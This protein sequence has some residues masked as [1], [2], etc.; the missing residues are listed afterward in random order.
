M[1][2]VFCNFVRK[3]ENSTE[4][5]F[6]QVVMPSDVFLVR[7][8]WQMINVLLTVMALML[9]ML[10]GN[11]VIAVVLMTPSPRYQRDM[12]QQCANGNCDAGNSDD[13]DSDRDG[14]AVGDGHGVGDGTGNGDGDAVGDGHGGSGDGR[15]D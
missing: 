15:R 6:Q 14:D 8:I 11:M 4:M 12:A 10:L 13:G 7:A 2:F 3:T 1:Y 5:N 9:F